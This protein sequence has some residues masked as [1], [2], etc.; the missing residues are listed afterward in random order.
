MEQQERIAQLEQQLEQERRAKEDCQ[1][2]MA[3]A[4][5]ETERLR[6]NG[7]NCAPAVDEI[8]IESEKEKECPVF[9]ANSVMHMHQ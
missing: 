4:N 7:S 1:R 8:E 5:R 9:L 3:A 6:V 2:K